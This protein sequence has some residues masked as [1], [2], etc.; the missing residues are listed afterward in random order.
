MLLGLEIDTIVTVSP[1][2]V[3]SESW[4]EVGSQSVLF[5]TNILL[6][7]APGQSKVSSDFKRHIDCIQKRK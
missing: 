6:C 4:L 5:F 3:A 2:K 7:A 1:H